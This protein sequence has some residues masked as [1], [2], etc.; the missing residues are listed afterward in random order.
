MIDNKE[1]NVLKA[2]QSD[3][4]CGNYFYHTK[5]TGIAKY[6]EQRICANG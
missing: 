3:F 5:Y 6:A 4:N 2:C 1:K